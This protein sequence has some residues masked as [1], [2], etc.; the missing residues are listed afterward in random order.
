[1]VCYKAGYDTGEYAIE[2]R[3]K[4]EDHVSDSQADMT[5]GFPSRVPLSIVGRHK[6][7]QMVREEG[8]VL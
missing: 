5:S 3:K 2:D 8:W 1:M 4:N 6:Q 7:I